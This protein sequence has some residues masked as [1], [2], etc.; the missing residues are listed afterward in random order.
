MLQSGEQNQKWPTSV[1]GGYMT[2]AAWGVTAASERGTK[3]EMAHKWAGWLHNP[4]RPEAPRHFREGHKIRSGPHVGRV[5]ILPLPPRGSPPLQSR[6][7][8]QN[9]GPA[10]CITPA[11]QEVPDALKRGTKSEV[12]QVCAGWL[13]GPC[14]LVGPRCIRAGD[15]IRT[16]PQVGPLAT[17]PLP[18]G[19]SPMV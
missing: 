2:P 5:A 1:P 19:G 17:E 9:C 11:A 3:S 4:C 12:A 14:R 10:G 7:H 16:G 13:H 8:N 6:E 18:L 15:K